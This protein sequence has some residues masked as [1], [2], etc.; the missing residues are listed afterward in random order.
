MK[1]MGLIERNGVEYWKTGIKWK[2]DKSRP[3]RRAI[4]G[5]GYCFTYIDSEGTASH[6]W[7]INVGGLIGNGFAEKTYVE[8]APKIKKP[9]NKKR[10]G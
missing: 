6:G 8:I 1:V 7:C 3:G 5:D 2:V 9:Q 4:D 10:R